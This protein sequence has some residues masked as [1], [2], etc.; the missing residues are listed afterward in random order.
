[1]TVTTTS[2]L[3]LAALLAL[4]AAL[5]P[6]ALDAYLPSFPAIAADFGIEIHAV[7]L[8]ISAYVFVIS[9]GQLVGGPLSDR[10][11]RQPVL[12]SGLALFSLASLGASQAHTLEQL[13][14]WRMLQAIG[15]GCA[16]VC[17]PALV[18][19]RMQGRDAAKLFSLIGLTGV[20]APAIAPS[21]GSLLLTLGGWNTVFWFL[22]F[23]AAGV[24]VILKLR[25]FRGP[26]LPPAAPS[27]S[28][29]RR[30]GVVL[31][32]RPALRFMFLQA[33]AF[34]VML[35]FITHSSFIYQQHFGVSPSLFGLFFGA[36][37]LM[38]LTMNL[39]NRRLLNR[40]APQQILRAALTLQACGL[41]ALLLIMSFSPQLWLFLP[42]MMITIGAIGAIGPNNM[43]CCMEFFAVNGGTAAALMG[44]M[45]FSVAGTLS[46]LSVL[47]PEN[48]TAIILAQ[49]ACSLVCLLLVW[50]PFPP[51]IEAR[52]P[53]S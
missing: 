23:Y 32:T 15:G 3:R 37:I 38:M 47:L 46:A 45:Q 4:T 50:W 33:F 6:L 9:F 41:A 25:L 26:Q 5:G 11:G 51:P 31:Q 1:M 30:Y 17:V 2:S 20:A 22:T 49:A 27:L 8:T 53:L 39:A 48:V 12:L 16:V 35:L 10:F 42:A 52:P 34:S 18:R 40:F 29:W 36:N 21:L 28:L 7:S 44:A 43:A 19:D 13:L 14:L 24:L